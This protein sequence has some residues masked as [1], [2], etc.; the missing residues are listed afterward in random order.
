MNRAPVYVFPLLIAL[1]YPFCTAKVQ[2]TMPP[3]EAPLAELWQ[4][5]TISRATICLTDRGAASGRRTRTRSIRWCGENSKAPIPA[6]RWRI[7]SAA[8]GTSSNR[9]T[10]TRGPKDR[11]R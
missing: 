3:S 10:T 6:S 7:Q 9:H 4:R 11:S 1:Y 8:S 5:P 2:P